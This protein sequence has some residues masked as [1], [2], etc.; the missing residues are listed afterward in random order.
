MVEQSLIPSI[1]TTN[2]KYS[3]LSIELMDNPYAIGGATLA[4]IALALA[5]GLVIEP[6]LFRE[7]ANWK[8]LSPPADSHG[9]QIPF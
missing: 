2:W 7:R 4:V 9:N 6:R 1:W 3:F 8:S 5:S